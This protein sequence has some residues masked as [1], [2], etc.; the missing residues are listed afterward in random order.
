MIETTVGRVLF[1][2]IL[3]A[4]MPFY[5]YTL[6]KRKLNGLISDCHKLLGK[7][8][9]LR[10]LD[11]IKEIG[12]K[13]AT[14]AGLSFAKNDMVVPPEKVQILAEAEDEVSE[15]RGHLRR[16][17]ITRGECYSKIIDTW[18]RAREEVG[19]E[20]MRS[21]RRDT[22]DD[23]PYLNPISAMADSG[24]R[25]SVEQIRQLAGMR[26]LMAKPSGGSSRRPSSRTSAKACT[27]S[28]TSRRRTAPARAWPTPRSRRRT[29]AT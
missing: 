7:G 8:A 29:R 21:L 11:D 20:M 12:F 27:S 25:G 15:I 3:P 26:G 6:D 5:N 16:G 1:N 10:L 9:T 17:E 22:R 23:K 24:A 14:R 28:S 19:A 13:S 4:G 2:D 18:T